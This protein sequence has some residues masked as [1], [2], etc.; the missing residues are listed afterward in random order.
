[1]AEAGFCDRFWPSTGQRWVLGF[2][3]LSNLEIGISMQAEIEI[4]GDE[5][6]IN[7][8]VIDSA[9]LVAYLDDYEEE[10]RA[11]ALEGLI[12][13][14][15]DIR[16][17]FQTDLE[18]QNIKD[19]A[20]SVIASIE[21]AYEQM[22][23]DLNEKLAE[24][25]DPEKGPVIKALDKATGDNLKNLLAPERTEDNLDPSP[26][27]RLRTLIA[28][29]L[30]AHQRRVDDS[31]EAIK[32][33]L[34]INQGARKTAADGTD[35]EVKVDKIIQD[36]AQIFGDSAELTG[37]K[38]E[39][40]GGKKG[41]TKVTLNKDDTMGNVCTL[42]W[43]AKTDQDFKSKATKRVIDDQVKKELNG[44]I[45]E[46]SADAAILV[47]DSEGIDMDVQAPWKEYDG[48]KLLIIVDTFSPDTDLIRLAYLWGRWKSRS[49]IGDL[50]AE[51]DLDGIRGSFD[52]MQLRLKDL[53]N[54]KKSHNDAIKSIEG[55]G[56]L[57]KSF[58]DDI[59]SM[60]E[61]L[62]DMVNVKIE[63]DNE[64]DELD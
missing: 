54:V 61:D 47:L 6:T 28:A 62:A 36:Y 50:K 44:V 48:N 51:I 38:A 59:R 23:E 27:A 5:V 9:E 14:A 1:M 21:Q 17:K 60:M 16:S 13:I 33:K 37:A 34:R 63:I 57:L 8:L 26:I 24:I 55:A 7:S 22:V 56:G 43:E 25:V 12:E 11:D 58:R 3:P 64:K 53:R 35:F 2:G 15:L 31:L 29:D 10:D 41:D 49:S 46:R 52:A 32:S 45:T 42:L 18:T 4:D 39:T 40:G 30:A 19:S 20:E